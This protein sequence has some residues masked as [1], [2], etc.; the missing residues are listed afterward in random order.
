MITW[1]CRQCQESIEAPESLQGE[2]LDC[3]ICGSGQRVPTSHPDSASENHAQIAEDLDDFE[4][5]IGDYK[6]TVDGSF[7]CVDGPDD[8]ISQAIADDYLVSLHTEELQEIVLT[9]KTD[10]ILGEALGGFHRGM[11]GQATTQQLR[12][13]EDLGYLPRESDQCLHRAHT[14]PV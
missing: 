14:L 10:E 7:L 11:S 13:A 1:E 6:L 2:P 3:P 8:S 12:Y 4:I 5:Q 9:G